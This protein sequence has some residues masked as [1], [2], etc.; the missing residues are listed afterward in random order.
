MRLFLGRDLYGPDN[1]ITD[2]LFH[3]GE[4]GGSVGPAIGNDLLQESG[5]SILLED[6]GHILLEDNNPPPDENDLLLEDGFKILLEDGSHILL[7]DATF[8][9]L[10]IQA[11]EGDFLLDEAGELIEAEEA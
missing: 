7:E 6:G 10:L 8:T 4:K 11:E 5:F 2:S 9:T 3:A 1:P